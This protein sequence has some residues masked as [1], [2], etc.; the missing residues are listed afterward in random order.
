MNDRCHLTQT[1][2]LFIDS[3]QTSLK[4][5]LLANEND[6][7][8]V[9][10]AYSMSTK[11]TYKNIS[12]I[13]DKIC[14]EDYNLKLCADLKK[15]VALLTGLQTGSTKYCCF[16]SEWGS[17]GRNKHYIIWNWAWRDTYSHSEKCCS[18]SFGL[19]GKYFLATIAHQTPFDQTIC[20]SNG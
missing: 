11:E 6:L 3:S 12:Q 16:Q 4:V 7:P 18:W 15:V 1:R 13:L 14:Y 20:E 9:V 10:V 19:K 2:R 8:P 5:V 17:R